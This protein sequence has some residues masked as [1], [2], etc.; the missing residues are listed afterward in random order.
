MLETELIKRNL[1]NY[2]PFK[3]EDHVIKSEWKASFWNRKQVRVRVESTGELS[4]QSIAQNH[5]AQLASTLLKFLSCGRIKSLG[6]HVVSYTN[7][8]YSVPA[9]MAVPLSESKQ[10]EL[11]NIQCEKLAQVLLPTHQKL[12]NMGAELMEY[13][14]SRSLSQ[15]VCLKA[16]DL[17][18]EILNLQY[19]VTQN[20]L[21]DLQPADIHT[22]IQKYE[23]QAKA[24][25]EKFPSL[26]KK[27]IDESLEE[28]T[29]ISTDNVRNDS[30]I[31]E[32]KVEDIHDQQMV[33]EEQSTVIPVVNKPVI[34]EIEVP[35]PTIKIPVENPV[36][37][38]T[39]KEKYLLLL[40]FANKHVIELR[41]RSQFLSSEWLEKQIK[42]ITELF[43]SQDEN[44]KSIKTATESLEN[45]L[46]STE[47]SMPFLDQLLALP[48]NSP[49]EEK[50]KELVLNDIRGTL[51]HFSEN[52]DAKMKDAVN[53]L[54]D[55]EACPWHQTLRDFYETT[56]SQTEELNTYH[57][58]FNSRIPGFHTAM[59]WVNPLTDNVNPLVPLETLGK[60]ELATHK[61]LVE[62]HC[63]KALYFL[64]NETKVEMILNLNTQFQQLISHIPKK[65]EQLEQS[66]QYLQLA[67]LQ[68]AKTKQEEIT[69][70]AST[71]LSSAWASQRYAYA[72]AIAVE[73]LQ[74]QLED[75]EKSPA[76]DPFE[77]LEGLK[78]LSSPHYKTLHQ[79]LVGKSKKSLESHLKA[80]NSYHN[81]LS[82]YI[83]ILE[84][85]K[86]ALVEPLK[87]MDAKIKSKTAEAMAL[88]V[89]YTTRL[90]AWQ[91]FSS[92][93]P[94]NELPPS[95]LKEYAD[96]VAVIVE[97]GI[98]EIADDAATVGFKFD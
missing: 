12:F 42:Q 52:F 38:S 80:L 90:H 97:D 4:V 13:A 40:D 85:K 50:L 36:I 61:T 66:G 39:P 46:D 24:M 7:A 65:L 95:K 53:L 56:N 35:A 25:L 98:E 83:P 8:I 45:A 30:D 27:F 89:D 94:L 32:P 26:L 21:Q 84:E 77:Q 81:T 18:G 23:I 14:L 78:Q 19:S 2:I 20:F 76:T 60:R 48:E 62:Q 11:F 37:P 67:M 68:N 33:I 72:L 82:I 64:E 75:I 5:L 88:S 92:Q 79:Q 74:K 58:I 44:E 29:G 16:L 34:D 87:A 17:N 22:Q 1:S 71:S 41:N 3:S 57:D 6:K 55:S 63:A 96:K 15:K 47:E 91:I 59:H 73:G 49:S 54:K 70:K 10:K 9:N 28:E 93:I 86:N 69:R 51:T 43:T 31:S